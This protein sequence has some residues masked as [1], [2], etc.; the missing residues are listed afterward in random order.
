M[1]GFNQ[2]QLER[3]DNWEITLRE[4]LSDE[5]KSDE[6]LLICGSLYFISLVRSIFLIPVEQVG[7]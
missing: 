2:E 4:W 5:T 6:T 1:G 7:E 3:V